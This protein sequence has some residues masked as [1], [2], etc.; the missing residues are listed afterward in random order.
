MIPNF[1]TYDK[2]TVIK[3]YCVSVRIQMNGR[4]Q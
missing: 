4:E 2:D 1:V 3:Q